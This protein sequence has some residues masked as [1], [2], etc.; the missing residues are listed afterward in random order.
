MIKISVGDRGTLEKF[1]ENKGKYR[2]ALVGVE[3][4]WRVIQ[5]DLHELK[6]HIQEI[7][8]ERIS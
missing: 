4:V 7:F 8:D 1:K 5:N 6:E 3:V 2:Y